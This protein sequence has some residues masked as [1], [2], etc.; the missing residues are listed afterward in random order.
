VRHALVTGAAGGLGE[1]IAARLVREG[2]RVVVVD[3]DADAI[4]AAAERIGTADA[5]AG[6]VP[7]AADVTDETA[8]E[9]ALDALGA[10]P[11][12]AVCNAGLLRTGPLLE[13]DV[14]AFRLVTDVNLVGVFA[15]ARAAARRMIDAGRGGSIV[16][17]ASVAG[18]HANVSS[19]A[20]AA[21]KAGV[22]RLTEQM[23]L[24]WGAHG[25]RVNAIAPGFIDAG[26]STPF[27]AD[28][29][30]RSARAGAT[31]LGRLGTADDV[32]DVALFLASDASGYVTG[33]NIVVDGGVI[34]SI[35]VQVP[36]D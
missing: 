9:A 33:Q 6:A 29:A 28:A 30:V 17:M 19:G 12:L 21:T 25:I 26:M 13:H 2:H 4:S 23:A 22:I 16:N 11:D 32:A 34:G 15:T 31:P 10:A 14:E 3:L 20:Y 35:L 36:R 7:V 24:E 8:L 1:A 5:G 18:V 27:Y